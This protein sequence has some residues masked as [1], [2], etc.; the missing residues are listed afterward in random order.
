MK[1]RD[2]SAV[3]PEMLRSS[4]PPE[5]PALEEPQLTLFQQMAYPVLLWFFDRDRAR[6]TG[7]TWLYARVCIELA[8]RGQAVVLDDAS[9]TPSE[10]DRNAR[11]SRHFA[12]QV[13]R[14]AHE[15][16]PGHFFEYNH[17]SNT[18]RYRGRRPR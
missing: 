14:L 11:Q 12:D 9:Q 15:K 1:P 18:L 2:F 13:L 3:D 17:Q 6:G 8:M 4:F 16:F 7:K 5:H 10:Y